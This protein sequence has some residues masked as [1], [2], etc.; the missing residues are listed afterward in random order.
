MKRLWSSSGCVAISRIVRRGIRQKRPV[1]EPSPSAANAPVEWL[2]ESTTYA[3]THSAVVDPYTKSPYPDEDIEELLR[4]GEAQS[5]KSSAYKK[6]VAERHKKRKIFQ[7]NFDH[8]PIEEQI[9]ALFPGQGAQHVGMGSKL[10]ECPEACRVYDEASEI[11]GYDIKK[12]CLEGPKSKLDQTIY[13]QPAVFVSSMAALELAKSTK[14]SFMDRV[15]DTAGFSV[16][17]YAALVLAGVI[18]FQDALR[19]VNTRAKLMHECNQRIAS[20]MVTVRVSAASRLD[21]AMAD[22]RE[23]AS[24]KGEEP[25][26]EIANFLFCGVKV[27]GASNT[28]LKFLEDNQERYAFQVQLRSFFSIRSS[29]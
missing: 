20:G 12:L 14:N 8:I 4:K 6:W 5:S 15:T 2:K 13:C 25:I 26:C 3:D 16:G 17:E 29:F 19:L 9:V 1:P 27:V 21:E 24:E 18:S 28:C 7:L 10:S 11:L 22:A 23:L